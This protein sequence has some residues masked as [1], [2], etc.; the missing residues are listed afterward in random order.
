MFYYNI[1]TFTVVYSLGQSDIK[2]LKRE[3]EMLKK[4]LWYLRDEYDKLERLIKEK[5]IGLSSPS[6]C[7]TSNDSV[8]FNFNLRSY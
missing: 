6:T 4:G 7:S 3:N 8:S 1:R 5:N 2:K